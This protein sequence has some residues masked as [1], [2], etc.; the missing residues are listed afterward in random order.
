MCLCLG[1]ANAVVQWR[2]REGP[3]PPN[4]SIQGGT[5]YIPRFQREYAG[6]YICTATTPVRNYETS[7]FIIVTGKNLYNSFPRLFDSFNSLIASFH[8]EPFKLLHP[9]I[10]ESVKMFY[11]LKNANVFEIEWTK[12]SVR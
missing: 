2:R 7:V 8:S 6:E 1:L 11:E 3:L 9:S 4:H 10:F 12:L 5:L